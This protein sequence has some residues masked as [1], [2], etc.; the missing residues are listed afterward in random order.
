MVTTSIEGFEKE[1]DVRRGKDVFK[2]VTKAMDYLKEVGVFFGFECMV[3]Y[4]F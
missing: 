3:T 4:Q 1:T 2:K